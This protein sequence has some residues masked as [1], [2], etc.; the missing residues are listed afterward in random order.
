MKK[1]ILFFI[2]I[3]VS[4]SGIAN[5]VY[6]TQD[7]TTAIDQSSIDPLE[8]GVRTN[9]SPSI[10]TVLQGTMY[11]L[12]ATDYKLIAGSSVSPTATSI[13]N[14]PIPPEAI[15]DKVMPIYKA[16]LLLAGNDSVLVVDT[17][18][19]LITFEKIQGRG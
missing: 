19:K 2:F 8:L 3:F 7:L 12:G 11:V 9:Y 4:L 6:V 14:R 13:I 18:H 10:N 1:T 15:Q 16:L 17:K 5:V